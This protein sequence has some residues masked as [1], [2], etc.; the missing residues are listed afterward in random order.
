MTIPIF[1]FKAVKIVPANSIP[2]LLNFI[3]FT[4]YVVVWAI[5]LVV[6]NNRESKSKIRLICK[7][8]FAY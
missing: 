8:S 4:V 3:S 2:L 6:V 7:L 5:M 1:E